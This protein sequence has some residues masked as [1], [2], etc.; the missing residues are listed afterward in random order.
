MKYYRVKPEHDNEQ[1]I[2]I[3]KR[4]NIVMDGDFLVSNQLYTVKEWENVTK[5]HVFR[6]CNP[7][8]CVEAVE[9]PKSKIYWFFGARFAEGYD[10]VANEKERMAAL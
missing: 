5:T 1:L 4:G 10:N 3:D 9:I 8:D 7:A 6:Q 2:T